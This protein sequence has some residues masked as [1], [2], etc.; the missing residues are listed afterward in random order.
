MKPTEY[1]ETLYKYRSW[2]NEYHQKI[3]T[4]NQLYLASPSD[5]NDPIDCRIGNNYS[6]LDTDEKIEEYAEIITQRHWGSVVKMGLNP[7]KE[8]KRIISELKTNM[9]FVQNGDDENTFKMQDKYYGILSLSSR[10]DSILMWSHYAEFHKGFCIGFNETKLRESSMFGKGGPVVYNNEFP[11]INPRDDSS[12]EKSFIQT[13]TK[14]KDWSYEEEYRLTKLFYPNE[15]K[16]SDRIV[17]VP[18]DFI[19]EIVLGLKISEEH[20]NEIIKIAKE[21]GLEIYQI[22]QVP[23]EFKLIKKPVYNIG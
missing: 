2:S 23:F 5:F 13:H 3:L 11:K 1:P 15:P 19:S 22:E 10:Y 21:K 7:I 9:D 8:K 6:L 17:T 16:P 14:A 18:N 20:K 4:E 12:P